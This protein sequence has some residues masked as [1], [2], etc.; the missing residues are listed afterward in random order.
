MKR[1]AILGST[2]SIG[3]QALEVVAAHPDKFAVVGLAAGHNWE[4]LCR[5][6]EAF[7][8][9]VLAVASEEGAGAVSGRLGAGVEVYQ[10]REGLETVATLPEADVVLVAV[11]GIVGLAP[12]VAA[13]ASG[14]DI[15]LANKETLVA[16]G[17]LVTTLAQQM[18]VRLLPVD[19]EHAAVWQCV[20]GRETEVDLIYLTAS[21]GPFR[22]L[23]PGELE[24]V[25][26][27]QALRHPTWSMGAKITIDSAT[28]MNKGLEVI[29]A[30]W[31]F[32]ADYDRIRVL[33]HPQSIVHGMVEL[34]DGTV[35]ACLS[36]PDMRLPIQYALGYPARYNSNV[37]R[38]DFLTLRELNFFAP[39]RSRFPCLALAEQAGRAG[40]TFPAVL[41]AANEVAVSAFLRSQIRF[42]SIP[43]VIEEVLGRHNP[44]AAPGLE[45]ILTVDA[46]AR[47][48]AESIIRRV[49][50]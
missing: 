23:T 11:T 15:A 14:K 2:G 35:I 24:R 50:V 29:E 5:Q 13:I 34:L 45:D 30:H 3:R 21:G 43:A 10:G 1:I 20:Q 49:R 25:T 9:R 17:R 18:G 31:L 33:I 48:E 22:D 4:L 38:L 41:N 40:Q 36:V 8:V 47:R 39:D 7:G 28:L 42:S 26:P 27:E 44:V 37:P 16:G 6:A 46:W 12:T 19:S 32:G